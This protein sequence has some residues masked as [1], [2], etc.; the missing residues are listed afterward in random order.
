[1]IQVYADDSLVYDSRLEDYRLLELSVTSSIKAAGTATLKMPPGHPAYNSFTGYRS[2]VTVYKDSSLLWRGR[3]LYPS[4][5]FYKRRTIT[6]E[7]ERCFLRDGIMRPYIYQDGP[8]AI[9][10]DVIGLYNAQVEAFKQ[11]A[12]GTVTVTDPNNYIRIESSSAEQISDTINK[13]VDRCGGYIVFTTNTDGLRTINWLEELNYAS[14]QVI[15]FGE[16][17]L[18][19]ARADENADLATVLVP[20]GAQLEDGTRVTIK[21]VNDDLDFIQDYDAVALRGVIAKS[22]TWD[23]VTEPENLLR[24][25]QQYLASAKNM[26]TSLTLSAVDLS[27]LDKSIDTFKVGDKV[28]VRSK[29]HGVDDDFQLVERTENLLDPSQ[30]TVTLGKTYASLTGSDV[31]GDRQTSSE[32][33][34]VESN[35][36]AE[37]KL[38]IAAAVESVQTTLMTLIQQTSE[39]IKLEVS[40]T[41][42]TNGDVESAISTSMTQLSDSFNFL[43]TQLQATV[44]ENDADARGQFEEIHKY[45]RFEDGNIILGE[46]GNELTLHI[47]N[48]RISFLDGGAEVAYFSNKQLYVTDGRFTRSLRIGPI[49]FIPRAS[50]ST[51]LVYVGGDS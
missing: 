32:L 49:E 38:N 19:Y 21:S 17:L 46:S 10:S 43:F 22:K 6:C 13:L 14:S 50:G 41:Y 33:N 40:E 23:D 25:A 5:D 27:L 11:F 39:A 48:D 20:Y 4:D 2:V 3:S 8:A 31:A 44:D 51:S 34:R 37:Y 15:E 45:I 42:A 47:E 28:R 29:P 36:R 35:I 12:V 24:K 7:G 18:D 16:N 9:F 1:M 30:G 26:L